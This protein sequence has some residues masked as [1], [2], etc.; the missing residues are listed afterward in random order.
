MIAERSRPGTRLGFG[1][2]ALVA[3]GF[4]GAASA[5]PYTE[6]TIHSFVPAPF[7][8]QPTASL[9]QASDG[10]LYGTTEVGGSGGAGTVFKISNPTTSPTES[11]VYSFMGGADGAGPHASLIQASD[12]NLYGTTF[13]GGSSGCGGAGCG[14]VFKI[15]NPSTS[16]AESVI[17]SFT[18]GSDGSN[19]YASL[20]Q[21]SDGNLYG[22]TRVGGSGGCNDF[23]GPGCGTAFK[24]SNP[25]TSPAESVIY[26]FTGGSDGS[27][28]HASLIQASDGNLYGTTYGGGSSG[29]GGAGC[30]TVFKISNPATSP[31]ESVIYGFTEG[32]DG[33]N[34]YASLIQAS[35]GNL[36]GA[37][38]GG[39]SRGA[40]TVFKISD[41]TTSPS[42]S[43]I[44][45]FLTGND[46]INPNA[47]LI[48]ASDGNLYGTTSYGG[49]NGAGTVFEISNPTTS[50]VESVI[51][52]FTAG[53][54]GGRPLASLIQAFDG[55]LYGTTQFG[56]SGGWGTVFKISNPTTSPAESVIYVF[57]LIDGAKPYASL[58]QA[59]DGN[60]YG[61][62]QF[63]GPNRIGTVLKISNPTTSPTES[64]IHD[65]TGGADGDWPQASL[66][67]ASDGNL[68]GTT[69]YGGS[70]NLGTVFKISNPMTSPAESVIYSFMGG[71][72]GSNPLASLIQASD[73]NLYGT[74]YYGGSGACIFGGCGTVFK[75]SNP[76]TSPTESVI[77]SF[78]GGADG[79]YP[80]A[81]L[82]QASDGNLYGT[83]SLGWG[84]VFRISNPTTSP[85]E[86]VIYTFTAG[87]D[88]GW[89]K[90]SLIQAS[91]GN[92]YGTTSGGGV[93]G[94]VFKISNL[95]GTPT[96]SVIYSF[97]GGSDGANPSASLIHASDGSLFG[98]TEYGG[99]GDCFGFGCGTVFKISNPTTSPTESVIHRFTGGSDGI[100][101]FASLIQASD[102]NLYGTTYSGGSA[103][104]GT[105]FKLTQT[106]CPPITLAPGTLPNATLGAPYSQ[107]ITASGGAPPYAFTVSAG[108]LPP[109]LSMDTAGNITGTPT[110]TGAYLFTVT[111]T[112]ANGCAGSRSYVITVSCAAINLAPPTLPS[113]SVGTAYNQTITASGGTGPYT[114]SLGG[115]SLPPGLSLSA[116]GVISGTP[117]ASG[118][119]SFVVTATDSQ[120][121]FGSMFYTL[122]ISCAGITVSPASLPNAQEGVAYSQTISASGGSGSY[123]FSA[124]GGVPPGL[125]L[126]PS[127]GV[128][129]GTPTA[130]GNFLFTVTATDS[131]GCTGSQLYLITV[132]C[133][134]I[135]LSPTSLPGGNVGL[136]YSQ[137][138][139]ASGGSAPYTFA[140][141]GSLPPGVSLSASGVLSGTPTAAGAYTFQVTATDSNGCTG[142]FLYTVTIGPA[143]SALH[144]YTIA[145]CRL[146]DT[147]PPS[148]A[149]FGGPAIGSNETRS[150]PWAGQC[151]LPSDAVAV[152]ANITAPLPTADGTLVFYPAGVPV[153]QT[154]TIYVRLG[155]VRANNAQISMNGPFP[156]VVSVTSNIP[157]GSANVIVDVNGYFA[158]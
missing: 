93:A 30:G 94:T 12:G 16:P 39:G 51:Y 49:P 85:S 104:A 58:I 155:K 11:V 26:S 57:T 13:R 25:T 70:N 14:T 142:S 18:G 53:S 66:I 41:P 24:I 158:P 20:I 7:G 29:C 67:Q 34:P 99:V 143:G 56:G 105:V 88:G 96:E 108:A 73:G 32:A 102:G 147:R 76:S 92:L 82:I 136:A 86:S 153:P 133:A 111:A 154:T 144:Y 1:V 6:A 118:S 113:G 19:P 45:S 60:L 21:A 148:H 64:V 42:E 131:N 119:Y 110:A 79:G 135:N 81:S 132:S 33:S 121:C 65:F 63:G 44:Y 151:G 140:A 116:G 125:T 114:F 122:T 77:Y 83:G 87:A 156:G 36:Y 95:A 101:P 78:A 4:A 107:T 134:A 23:L 130:M 100:N 84:T 98:T 40:G 124:S 22:T 126:N 46:G 141:S 146:V 59:S 37:T 47:S 31:T 52:S 128:L 97:I 103:D 91:D 17:Y 112:D 48:Q 61:T 90:A 139:T 109:G 28:P 123:T 106:P 50:P 157:G 3:L 35:D 127:T 8:E 15:S 89:P 115:G 9:I 71:S 74:T 69:Y 5:Q 68:Y 145:P 27:Y 80:Q 2:F 137:T 150:W 72:D 138:I 43:V 120:G 129:S 149:P 75:I 10:N 62:T 38:A 54:D 55:N 152:S 117:T